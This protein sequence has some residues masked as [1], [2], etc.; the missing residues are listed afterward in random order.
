[1]PR[2]WAETIDTHRQ[3]VQE[4][5]LDAT[6]EVVAEQGP[7][8]VSMSVIAERAG[9]GRATLY[10]YFPDVESI[11]LAWHARDFGEQLERLRALTEA[12]SVGRDDI[13]DFVIAARRHHPRRG[14]AVVGPLA[15]SLAGA[16][17]RA[18]GKVRHEAVVVLADLLA[19]LA[20]DG[21]VRNDLDPAL[22]AQWL[23]HSV[24]A[25]ADL[26][27][28]AVGRLVADSLSPGA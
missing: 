2:I 24:H 20:R 11:L 27:D 18:G 19:R 22:L 8:S 16:G 21:Q 6:A 15:H 14:A 26:D 28:D 17:D 4:A 10:K 1:M 13:A 25:P 9:I 5:V 12:E 3:R 7:M 23:L